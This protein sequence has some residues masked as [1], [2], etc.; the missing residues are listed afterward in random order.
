MLFGGSP[1]PRVPR[2]VPCLLPLPSPPAW[3][4]AAGALG[5]R[6][7]RAGRA[8]EDS[9]R[10]PEAPRPPP[11][12]P[13]PGPRSGRPLGSLAAR[14]RC[15]ALTACLP[16]APL[17]L[18]RPPLRRPARGTAPPE[19]GWDSCGPGAGPGLH[20]AGRALAP[21]AGA[22]GGCPGSEPPARSR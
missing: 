17:P 9:G 18:R 8:G 14:W 13:L 16:R 12:R 2:P 20:H 19:P 5:E 15:A 4:A 1:S 6:S 7:G 22:Q 11:P 21:R 3:E 10:A